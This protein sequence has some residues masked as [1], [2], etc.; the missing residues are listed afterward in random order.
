MP[1]AYTRVILKLSGEVLSGDSRDVFDH[2]HVDAIADAII[3]TVNLGVQ[4][5]IVVGGGNIWRGRH[6][7]GEGMNAVTADHMGMLATCI[8][9]LCLQDALERKGMPTRVQS[10]VEMRQM[11][12][13]Y[14]R[15]R[16]IRH[17][18]KRRVVIFAAGI[19]NPHFST[20]TCAVLRAAEMDA[21]AV[22]K[23]TNVDALYDKDPR[24]HADAKPLNDITYTEALGIGAKVM[25]LTAFTLCQ[26]RSIPE[27]RIFNL[28]DPQNIIRVAKGEGLGSRVHI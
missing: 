4:V 6:G 18:E 3:E 21:D 16:A 15:R 22:L 1:A 25:D 26:E 11:C 13:P 12:E 19:G 10:A 27:I 23:G 20:D 7:Y 2:A 14:I 9:A 8:N 24:Q 5:G 28:N 17:L